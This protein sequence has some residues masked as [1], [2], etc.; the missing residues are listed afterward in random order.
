MFIILNKQ[1]YCLKRILKIACKESLKLKRI[2]TNKHHNQSE[3]KSGI[4]CLSNLILSV[5]NPAPPTDGTD[6]ES[7][8]LVV[9]PS[10]LRETP[11]QKPHADGRSSDPPDC[12]APSRTS[13]SARAD[14]ATGTHCASPQPGPAIAA[15]AAALEPSTL[16]QWSRKAAADA[17]RLTEW[18]LELGEVVPE[19][20]ELVR[21]GTWKVFWVELVEELGRKSTPGRAPSAL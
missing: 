6:W 19:R 4:R 2:S 15:A 11:L 21:H 17:E 9:P 7:F 13:D 18:R 3:I 5:I 16:R 14:L 12:S 10:H 8:P 1:L 20:L